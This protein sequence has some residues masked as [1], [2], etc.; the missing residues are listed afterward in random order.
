M[1]S[2]RELNPSHPRILKWEMVFV[3]VLSLVSVLPSTA[4]ASTDDVVFEGSGWGHGVGM[5][6]YGA[7]GMAVEGSSYGAILGHYYQ[8]AVVA[9]AVSPQPIW[10]NLERNF[11]TLTLT[12]GDTG[13]AEGSPVEITSA[14]GAMSAVSG[15]VLSIEFSPPSGC[16][17]TVT[18]PGQTATQVTDPACA[19]D[20]SWYGW[21]TPEANPTTKLTIAG[22]LLTDWN[23]APSVS[24]PCEYAR[25][26]LHLRSGQDPIFKT[27]ALDLSAEMLLD[28]Y[29][30]GISEMP[31]Y[32]TP[33][34]ALMAQAVASRSYGQ[35]MQLGR[36]DPA[37][38]SCDGWCHVKDTTADQRYVGWGH[39]GIEPW[40][41]SVQ[42]TAGEVLHHVAAPQGVVAAFFS[43][44]SGGATENIE[45]RFGGTPRP[46]LTSVDDTIAIDGTVP[47]P[48]ASWSTSLSPATVAAA[49]GYDELLT[50][51]VIDYR[52]SGSAWHLKFT[53]LKDGSFQVT[54]TT[55]TWAR[56]NFGLYSEY[57]NVE[58]EA[59]NKILSDE[60]F[61]YK[62]SDGV[63]KYYDVN[64]DGSLGAPL[65]TGTYS[66][67]WDSITAVDLDGDG[68]D[69]AFFYRSSDGLFKYYDVKQ[70]GSLGALIR[71]G[72]YSTGWSAITKVDL[73]GDGFDEF[74]FYRKSDGL[75]K[76]Y[77]VNP[78]GSLGAPLKSGLYSTGWSAITKVDL[79]GDGVD[80]FFFYRKSDGL[81]KYYAVNP[82]GAL[83]ALI[84][85]GLYS[86]GW[87]A[88]T[89][90][91]L[92]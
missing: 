50:V 23:V 8:G 2:S 15:A 84:K 24:R 78:S 3:V 51:E 86:T 37:T 79:D 56:T 52:T 77:D 42:A 27:W 58:Y 49:L 25:G 53:G 59:P 35:A 80:E 16:L 14:A 5:S 70:D 90:I 6:Q 57:F 21:S 85:T 9:Q 43:S 22:C 66:A 11:T 63:F 69:E 67:G 32:W 82:D 18:N 7:W 29:V 72:S 30:L 65:K 75:F 20:F 89:G 19:F 54:E 48:K 88:I 28:D 26:I 91:Q 68:V 55:G 64:P 45:E 83:G 81:F 87:S 60:L 12:V 36:G 47:N 44:S 10:V 38:N 17:V 34:Q 40:V 73:D 61:F 33:T 39:G 46:Y 13:V 62:S 76:Y 41:A 92:D 71:T 74:F 31:Y 1:V 4:G